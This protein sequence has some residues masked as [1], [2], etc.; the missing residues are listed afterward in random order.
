M[1]VSL[2]IVNLMVL[3]QCYLLGNRS[4]IP[5]ALVCDLA[6]YG[7]VLYLERCLASRDRIHGIR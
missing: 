6:K 2:E 5:K 3:N 7:F 4:F 1:A